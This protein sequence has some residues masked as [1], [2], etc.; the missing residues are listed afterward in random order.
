M[1][2][3]E[4]AAARSGDAAEIL[5]I[6]KSLIDT[7]PA[8]SEEYPTA[9]IINT[10][11]KKG[12]LYILRDGK[13]IVSAASLCLDNEILD[14]GWD[15]KKPIELSRLVVVK[16]MQRRG[17]G[18]LMLQLTLQKAKD[19]NFGGMILLVH[20]DNFAAALYEK[21]GFKRCGEVMLYGHKFY[22]YQLYF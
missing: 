12:R 17:I 16:A 9:E 7:T 10:D 2:Q 5:E 20:K 13:N 1:N 14:L 15:I 18:A 11:I 19:K 6:Y 8:W 4:F 3:Y 22:K 21:N